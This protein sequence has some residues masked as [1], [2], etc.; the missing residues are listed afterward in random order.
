MISPSVSIL[1]QPSVAIVDDNAEANETEAVCTE[2]LNYL[3]SEP[4]QKLIGESGYRPTDETVLRE[5]SQTFDLSMKLWSVEDFGGW[6]EAYKR[7]FDDGAMFDE[8]YEYE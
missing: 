7:Y 6:D 1:A 5:F 8:I 4:A 3:Y 2:Y